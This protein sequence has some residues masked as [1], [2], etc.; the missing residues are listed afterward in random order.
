MNSQTLGI[1]SILILATTLFAG[2]A[3]VPAINT[4]EAIAESPF[5]DSPSDDNNGGG[6]DPPNNKNHRGNN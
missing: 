4:Q 5:K 1:L 2:L 3:I 6:N